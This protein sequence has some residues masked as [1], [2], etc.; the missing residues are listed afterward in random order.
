MEIV[1]PDVEYAEIATN[2]LSVDKEPKRSGVSK[3]ITSS[4]NTMTV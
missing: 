1:F 4:G 3:L 2:S